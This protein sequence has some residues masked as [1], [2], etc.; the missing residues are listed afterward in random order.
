MNTSKTP[1]DRFRWLEDPIDFPYYSGSPVTLS[2]RQWIFL[3]CT[4][5]LGFLALVLPSPFTPSIGS[6]L[7][8][9]ALFVA[10]PLI[11]LAIVAPK[12]W[13]TLFRKISLRDI[14]L[15]IGFWLIN[16]LASIIVGYAVLKLYGATPNPITSNIAQLSDSERVQLFARVIPQL[17]GEELLTIL[18]FL[19]ILYGL[20]SRLGFSRKRAV[21]FAWLAS[22]AL[23]AA[24]HLPTYNWNFV[25]C[26]IV[27]GTARLALT[28]PFIKTKNIWVSTGAH[29][30][31]DWGYLGVGLATAVQ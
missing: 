19:A 6:Q 24:A 12:H 11:G 5:L 21:V 8:S 7:L 14:K 20:H 3:M 26:F 9:T 27:I 25:Q 10:I 15:I 4:V 31:T 2:G 29:I 30:L 28:L 16:V 1:F 13:T 23:F 18:P 22:S 17:L